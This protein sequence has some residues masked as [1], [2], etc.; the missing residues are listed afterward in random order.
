R[1]CAQHHAVVS[2]ECFYSTDRSRL[3]VVELERRLSGFH[4]SRHWQKLFELFRAAAWSRAWATAAVR[5][6]KRFVEVEV[7]NVDAHV[8][9]ARDAD[10]C[11]HV[12]AVHVDEAAGFV[13]DVANLFD[14]PLKET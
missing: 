2:K 12:G 3:V 14:V 11:V 4:N 13:N 1:Q 5:S 8:A 7:N 6:G 10:E 9:G